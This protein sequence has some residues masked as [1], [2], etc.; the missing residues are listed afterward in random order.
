MLILNQRPL[1]V[2]CTVSAAVR[3]SLNCAPG[4]L[5]IPTGPLRQCVPLGVLLRMRTGL[6]RDHILDW[7]SSSAGKYLEVLSLSS[8]NHIKK[9]WTWWCELVILA[10]GS[11]RKAEPPK[12]AGQAGK[13]IW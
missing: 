5:L 11:Q 12:L 10:Q 7:E 4:A 8:R 2:S 1:C 13:L 3:V 6:V 9:T